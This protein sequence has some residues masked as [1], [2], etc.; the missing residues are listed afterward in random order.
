[1]K[2]KK[3]NRACPK[4]Q[5]LHNAAQIL[6]A[7]PALCSI[8]LA[9]CSLYAESVGGPVTNDTLWTSAGSPW[10]VTNT[11]TVVSN[12]TLTIEAGALVKISA[13]VSIN[14]Q[15]GG[16]IDIEGT[17][18]NP[19]LFRSL[20]DMANWGRVGASGTNAALIMKHADI[21]HGQVAVLDFACGL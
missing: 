15:A 2:T 18:A 5:R 6:W 8:L 16:V 11:V 20:D 9:A 1:M 13:A 21:E 12:V 4:P 17:S 7:V 3:Q 14:A 19:V 10:L